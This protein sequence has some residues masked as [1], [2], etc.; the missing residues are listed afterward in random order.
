MWTLCFTLPHPLGDLLL[1]ERTFVTI[2]MVSARVGE[3]PVA[4]RSIRCH[5]CSK[6]FEKYSVYVSTITYK[7]KRGIEIKCEM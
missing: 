1:R 3:E 4:D 7:E 6:V 5:P 2:F